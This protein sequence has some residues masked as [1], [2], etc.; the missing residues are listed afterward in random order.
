MRGRGRN[1]GHADHQRAGD[2]DRRVDRGH[3]YQYHAK[4]S[5]GR[6][7]LRA[8]FDPNDAT[9]IYAV[10]GGFS[11]GGPPGHVFRTTIDATTWTDISPALD[12]P[13]GALALDGSDTPTT[14]YAGTDFGVLRSIDGGASCWSVLDDIHFPRAWVTDLVYSPQARML[15][16]ATYGRGVF[17][18]RQPKG[19]AIAVNLE[20]RW[21]FGTAAMALPICQCKFSMLVGRIWSSTVCNA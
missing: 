8:A 15:R 19:A 11:G 10:M 12:V 18:F 5:P 1:P 20:D 21:D 13:F 14:I 16:A 9:V 2:H 6:N 7:V 17:E 3:D 4:S